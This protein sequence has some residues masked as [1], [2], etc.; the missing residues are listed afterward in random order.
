MKKRTT[1]IRFKASVFFLLIL[2]TPFFA[3]AEITSY[4][5]DPADDPVEMFQ[6]MHMTGQEDGTSCI[7]NA[8]SYDTGFE[9]VDTGEW[10]GTS[11]GYD[12]SPPLDSDQDIDENFATYP[13]LAGRR[14][15][16]KRYYGTNGILENYPI[17]DNT[18]CGVWESNDEFIVGEVEYTYSRTPDMSPVGTEDSFTLNF[19]WPDVLSTPY[20]FDFLQ[21]H[22]GQDSLC[23]PPQE[24]D[25]ELLEWTEEWGNIPDGIGGDMEIEV[26][27][28]N[29]D[30]VDGDGCF[31]EENN[32]IFM[33]GN[34]DVQ[35]GDFFDE[36]IVGTSTDLM[37]DPHPEITLAF[38]IMLF[39]MVF[40][41]VIFYF[42]DL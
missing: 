26:Q 42:R 11:S 28:S 27:F 10:F 24:N 35:E 34:I 6:S 16:Y 17:K 38:G 19:H 37:S 33:E 20:D 1:T 8:D 39:L 13:D 14:L 36:P 23:S 41:I 40:G 15:E 25:G 31:T 5:R 7:G 3:A 4:D 32:D 30:S 29:S 22:A 12:A 18:P 21:F 9:D 2:G